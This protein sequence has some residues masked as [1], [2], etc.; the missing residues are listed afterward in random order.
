MHCPALQVLYEYS[1]FHSFISYCSVLTRCL[2]IREIASRM[3][4]QGVV[5][6][7]EKAL[8]RRTGVS[9]QAIREKALYALTF[10]SLHNPLKASLCTHFMLLG[11]RH[12]FHHGTIG[13]QGAILQLLMNLHT[14][15]PHEQEVI[16]DIRDDILKLV[17][18]GPWYARYLCIKAM[19]VLF[20]EMDDRWYAVEHGVVE[21]ILEVISAKT[22]NLQGSPIV[23]FLHLCVHPE[24]PTL[25]IHKGVVKVAA[26]LLYAED[27]VIREL[28]IILLRALLLYN[29]SEVERCVNKEKM[30][31]L[32]RAECNPLLCGS[33]YGGLVEEYLQ[34]IV[35]NR[36]DR[37][38]LLHQF[39]DEEIEELQI[40]KE[41]LESYRYT[42]IEVDVECQGYLGVD[43][44]KMLIESKEKVMDRE[45]I[46][47]LLKEY[48]TNHSGNID[49]R[50]FVYMM[51]N[52]NNWGLAKVFKMIIKR[53]IVGKAIGKFK[54]W[55]EADKREA[56]QVQ[57]IKERRI[58]E[59]TAHRALT[60]K[61]LPHERL[62]QK[63]NRE[64]WLR[65][66]GLSYSPT[67]TKLPP[68]T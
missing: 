39:S 15:Y 57:Q 24:L 68:L 59:L 8:N 3:V 6:V 17:K 42:F 29:A 46:N 41:E 58:R 4:H 60:L 47:E 21:A 56:A 27:A 48:D 37:A 51:K 53:R 66:A 54:L 43:E 19:R 63:R 9:H 23:L 31:L 38:Y 28:S 32:K 2:R 26:E 55:W 25:L 52:W 10:L 64:I 50:E 44:L 7:L 36:K 14:H 20:Q 18:A 65:Q 33:E 5:P 67:Y 11:I 1:T 61:H 16:I 30:Y 40:T 22:M 45:E 62:K 35:E 13:E 49:F 12:E 34:E